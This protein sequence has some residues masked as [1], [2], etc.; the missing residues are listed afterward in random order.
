MYAKGVGVPRDNA[1]AIEY[2]KKGAAGIPNG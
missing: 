1:T 2:F